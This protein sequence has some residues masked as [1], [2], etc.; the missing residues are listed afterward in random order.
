MSE[1]LKQLLIICATTI[2]CVAFMS[3]CAVD[4]WAR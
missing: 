3:S 2:I 4:V 1:D